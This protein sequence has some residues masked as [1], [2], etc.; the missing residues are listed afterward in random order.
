M[1]WVVGVV[2]IV[3]AAASFLTWTATRVDRLHTRVVAAARA[4]EAQ[5][6]RRAAAVAV[7]AE[8]RDAPDLYATARIALD[9]GADDRETAENDLTRLLRKHEL[10]P[11][12]PLDEAVLSASRRVALARQVHTDSVRDALAVRSGAMV[13]ALGLTHRHPEPRYFDIDEPMLL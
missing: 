3:V 8:A 12:D 5:L 6:V 9:N 13:K 1:G 4:L 7:L 10:D 11:G 2:A